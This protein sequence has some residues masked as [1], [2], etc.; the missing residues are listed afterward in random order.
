VSGFRVAVFGGCLGP[1]SRL[2]GGCQAV[3][4]VGRVGLNH[5]TYKV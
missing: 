2:V 4:M 1:K 3:V 5:D